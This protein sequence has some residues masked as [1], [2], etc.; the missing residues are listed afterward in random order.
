MFAPG[1]GHATLFTERRWKVSID[2]C[3]YKGEIVLVERD[4]SI[5][6]NI[7]TFIWSSTQTQM[8]LLV[9]SEF[10]FTHAQT[11]TRMMHFILE[12]YFIQ[13]TLRIILFITIF[14][15]ICLYY[16]NELKHWELMVTVWSM[17][18]NTNRKKRRKRK[19]VELKN[20]WTLTMTSSY[21]EAN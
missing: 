15:Y 4:E 14:I 1:G 11:H 13:S 12:K 3:P 8:D 10:V 18:K 16:N 7:Y 9:E 17:Y 5:V 19:F 21:N 20:E 2:N 6:D